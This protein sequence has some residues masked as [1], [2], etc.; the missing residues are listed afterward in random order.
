MAEHLATHV[1]A[2]FSGHLCPTGPTSTLALCVLGC[3]V[4]LLYMTYQ[5]LFMGG[6]ELTQS[7]FVGL[8]EYADV[9]VQLLTFLKLPFTEGTAEA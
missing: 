8:V 7:T 9:A 1:T 5:V 2:E 3:D 6:S 4:G